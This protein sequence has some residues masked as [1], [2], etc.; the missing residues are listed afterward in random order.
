M[1]HTGLSSVSGM[2]TERGRGGHSKG[3]RNRGRRKG[4]SKGIEENSSSVCLPQVQQPASIKEALPLADSCNNVP[5]ISHTTALRK[6]SQMTAT[7]MGSTFEDVIPAVD[8][9]QIHP[10]PAASSQAEG[11]PENHRGTTNLRNPKSQNRQRP[12][13]GRSAAAVSVT[14]ST[15]FT[16]ESRK[17]SVQ[18]IDMLSNRTGPVNQITSGAVTRESP[19]KVHFVDGSAYNECDGNMVDASSLIHPTKRRIRRRGKAKVG[20]YVNTRDHTAQPNVDHLAPATNSN[21]EAHEVHV[22]SP[23]ETTI[24]LSQQ[25][26]DL[27][28]PIAAR[29]ETP[30]NSAS[31][32]INCC[33]NV[34]PGVNNGSNVHANDSSSTAAAVGIEVD[35][36]GQ[37][38]TRPPRRRNRRKPK[39]KD[40]IEQCN[41]SPATPAGPAETIIPATLMKQTT[42]VKQESMV[43]T[44]TPSYHQG[45]A[46]I[47]VQPGPG[48]KETEENDNTVPVDASAPV[49]DTGTGENS[50]RR[51]R[52]RKNKAKAAGGSDNEKELVHAVATN[53]R[54]KHEVPQEPEQKRSQYQHFIPCLV[55]RTFATPESRALGGRRGALVN[56]YSMKDACI[57]PTP[58]ARCYGHPNMYQ[59]VSAT[60]EMHIEKALAVLEGLAARAV[61]RVKREQAKGASS[62]TLNRVEKNYIRKFLFVMKYRG[63][64]FWTKYNHALGDYRHA[65]RELVLEFMRK[66]GFTKPIEVWLHNLKTILDTPIDPKYD[67]ESTIRKNCFIHDGIWFIHNMNDFFMA[68]VQP[69]NPDNE[70]IIT[71]V[72]FGIHEG[73]TEVLFTKEDSLH[74][75]NFSLRAKSYGYYTE[76]HKMAPFSPKLLLVLRWHSL[77]NEETKRDLRE[78]ADISRS[79]GSHQWKVPSAFD[80]LHLDLPQKTYV[81]D[82]GTQTDEDTFEFTLHKISDQDVWQFNSLFLEHVRQNIT[83][84]SNAALKRT[85]IEYLNAEKFLEKPTVAF[86]LGEE[87]LRRHPAIIRREQLYRLLAILEGHQGKGMELPV[88]PLSSHIGKMLEFEG[89][90]SRNPF[91]QGY[92]KMGMF[93]FSTRLPSFPELVELEP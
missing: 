65:D 20:C 14:D 60:D 49:V 77:I 9:E 3:N 41:I 12:T 56:V 86:G 61:E 25:S 47:N 2:E 53:D 43:P 74:A 31:V 91:A 7:K 87:E 69:A 10:L 76:F 44:H 24:R 92:L 23:G 93:S 71:D 80:K 68:F 81:V 16:S 34:P 46:E 36:H 42:C 89:R 54:E 11:E 26:K 15:G 40:S 78:L 21:L 50:A 4:R 73:P 35:S 48:S 1:N 72:A 33:L 52:R 18:D 88:P 6:D 85:L 58:I 39:A 55:L 66:R 70:F 19:S 13:S 57:T 29:V 17:V 64:F 82:V 84:H 27:E 32:N 62:V 8:P 45:I 59:D 63:P 37:A 51:R 5:S 30:S 38:A 75:S 28:P 67:W 90:L 79:P 22:L 83:W